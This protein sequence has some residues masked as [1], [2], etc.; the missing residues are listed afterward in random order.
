MDIWYQQH[1]PKN[2]CK[3]T[4][5]LQSQFHHPSLPSVPARTCVTHPHLF[6]HSLVKCLSRVTLGWRQVALQS[7]KHNISHSPITQ[8]LSCETEGRQSALHQHACCLAGVSGCPH[9]SRV[10]VSLT[11]SPTLY[12]L[13][14]LVNR[15]GEID[16]LLYWQVLREEHS[17]LI[18]TSIH[19][20]THKTQT[21]KMSRYQFFNF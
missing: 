7:N 12:V 1:L 20:H 15:P 21:I 17:M 5:H 16:E 6:N 9:T 14:F 2:I 18:Y 10:P 8:S 19:K 4:Y 3:S 13:L 11:D